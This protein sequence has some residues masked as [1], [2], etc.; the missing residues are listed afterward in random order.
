MKSPFLSLQLPPPTHPKQPTDAPAYSSKNSDVEVVFTLTRTNYQPLGYFTDDSEIGGILQYKILEDYVSIIEPSA[1]M[2]L[3]V[4]SGDD[5]YV[6]TDTKS[7]W[8]YTVCNSKGSKC[9][10]GTYYPAS[11]KKTDDV[12]I[13]CEAGD[14]YEIVVVKYDKSGEEQYT[15]KGDALCMYVRRE[16]RTLTSDDLDATMDAM[17]LLWT[18]SES[19]GQAKYGD[20]YHSST[21]FTEAHHFNAAWQDGDHIHEGMGF[22]PQHL[23]MTNMFEAA[24]QSVD[25][26]V[27]LPYWDFTIDNEQGASIFESFIFTPNT[28]GSL[29]APSNGQYWTY[30]DDEIDD[31]KIPDGR[32]A[33]IEADSNTRF[34]DIPSAFGYMRGP[35]N[36]NPSTYITRY[37]SEVTSI[38]GCSAYYQWAESTSYGDFL[39]ASPYLPHASLHGA[40][41]GVYGCDMFDDMLSAGLIVD[42]SS[43]TMICT[44]WGFYL[45]ELYRGNYISPK[46]DCSASKA[47]KCGFECNDD[48]LSDM[49]GQVKKTI[50]NMYTGD[51][52]TS[53]WES[54]RDF[55]CD[56]DAFKVFV[57]DHLES[58]SP[59]DPSFWPIHPNQERMLHAKLMSGGFDD[60]SWPTDATED[61]VCDKS[62]CYESEYGAK[63]YYDDCC[64]GHYEDSQ[65]LNWIDADKGS[66]YGPTNGDVLTQ[67]DPTSKDY[68]MTYIYDDLKWSH[69]SASSD[70]STLFTQLYNARNT[71]QR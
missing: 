44:K 4:I 10:K 15:V 34:E 46:T 32:W 20:N 9:S 37:G 68:A 8:E 56:G 33:N 36:M 41:G 42:E 62:S 30:K 71:G 7:H 19:K 24:M 59:S 11:T 27:T 39:Y 63:G 1:P 51:L 29:P 48:Q 6:D 26:S 17:Y 35:W 55:I 49:A 18:K 64:Y 47:S 65:L 58:A 43:Q 69:C 60:W 12:T 38:P 22:L 52:S 53:Q 14:E 28:F 66:G 40:V 31:G 23:K 70:F 5:E 57:G 61:Y 50:N 2:S 16:I 3:Y 21:Y 54:W 67:T 25:A 45:K 13:K